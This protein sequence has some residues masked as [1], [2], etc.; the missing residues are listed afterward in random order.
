MNILNKKSV[1]ETNEITENSFENFNQNT[2]K[3]ADNNGIYN[4][5]TC[6]ILKN[7]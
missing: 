7:E 1:I 5:F 2:K 3:I 6:F 4:L